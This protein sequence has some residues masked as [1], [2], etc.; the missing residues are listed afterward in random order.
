MTTPTPAA[1]SRARRFALQ[2]LYQMQMTACSASE[3]EL[4]LRQDYDMKRVDTAYL[5]ELLDGVEV[6]RKVLVAA[7]SPKLD[8]DES[9]LDPIARAAL[10]IGAWEIM[11]RL[12]IPYRVAINESVELAKQFGAEESHKFVNSVLDALTIEYRQVEREARRD[13]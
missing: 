5:H 10:L 11:N 7:F 1:R 4:Q 6:Q 13:R 8:R 9:E 12:D 2:A 3:V